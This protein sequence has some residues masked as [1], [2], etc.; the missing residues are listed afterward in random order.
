MNRR[1]LS[2]KLLGLALSVLLLPA[3][4]CERTFVDD[5]FDIHKEIDILKESHEEM[6]K[7]LDNL[8]ESAV[9]LQAIIDV[10]SSGY[11]VDQIDPVL[12]AGVET[13]YLFHFTNGREITVLHGRDGLDGHTPVLSVTQVEGKYYWTV[14]GQL[15]VDDE[16]T[17][18]P[19]LSDTFTSP[20]FSISNGY[21]YLSFDGGATWRLLGQATGE[22]G[23]YGADGVQHFIRVDKDSDPKF[24]VFVLADGTVLSIPRRPDIRLVLDSADEA[25]P[26]AERETVQVGYRL[27]SATENTVVSVSS[28]GYYAAKVIPDDAQSG[29]IS[30]TC[31]RTYA[32]G[33]VNVLVFEDTGIVDS[34]I[35]RFKERSMTF[36]EGL[37][38]E[39]PPGDEPVLVPYDQVNFP[40]HLVVDDLSDTWLEIGEMGTGE[41]GV[42]Y[43]E[44]DRNEGVSRTGTV[45]VVP[46]NS[47]QV[48][49]A[50]FVTQQSADCT[51][52]KGS[53]VLPFEGGTVLS[54]VVTQEQFEVRVPET[55][56]E[57]L[58]AEV[59]PSGEKSYTV[60]I[61]AEPNAA[62]ESRSV[63]MDLISPEG[64]QIAG[65][66]VL[67]KGRNLDLE[68]AMVFIVNPNYS[69]DF[70]AYLPID[71]NYGFDCFVDWGDGTGMRYRKEDDFNAYPE[72]ERNIHHR[73]EG[74][75]VGRKFEVVV[76]GTVTALRASVIPLAYRSS[77]TEVKQWGKTGLTRMNRAFD[78]FSGLTTLPPDETGAFEDVESFDYAFAECANLSTVSGH[79]FD[80]ARSATSF[81]GTFSQCHQLTVIP[82][83]LFRQTVSAAS[84][85]RTFEHCRRLTKVPGGLFANCP[86][87]GSFTN[88]FYGCE[89]LQTVP[90]DL[91]SGNPKVA[92]F[93]GVFWEC[94]SLTSIPEGLFDGNPE[95]TDFSRTFENCVSLASVPPSLLDHQRKV[96]DCSRMFLNCRVLRSESPWMA[97]DGVKVHLYERRLYPDVFVF[98]WSHDKCFTGCTGL[99]DA[100][101]IPDSWK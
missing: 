80:H 39:V 82:D 14:D 17:P 24:V 52:D 90:A 7:R 99:P 44:A 58:K 56:S 23:Q 27:T 64:R 43:I 77:V 20:R 87:V 85:N 16:G 101:L 41:S 98:P 18:V 65:I 22:D 1:L 62:P 60:A 46:D 59:L 61:T 83:N 75:T 45:Y 19:V 74:L 89:S 95:A 38:F 40:F 28:D 84:F 73:Y 8:N 31:P 79:L 25:V 76:S 30:I 81:V 34:H 33:V 94:R 36:P 100:S 72:G 78:G 71:I 5:L 51:V 9:T 92:S 35:I 53:F 15:L 50:I 26:I 48:Y 69:N 3:T 86:E 10:L 49:A 42:I 21:W 55:E 2:R 32:D 57:W 11:F 12:E 6:R 47:E 93:S 67:Q 88:T 96:T 37:E 91:F 68:F 4:G 70:T 29:V 13:G 66:Q 97:V 54:N 63:L